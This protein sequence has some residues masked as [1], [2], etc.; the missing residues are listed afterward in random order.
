MGRGGENTNVAGR[1][2]CGGHGGAK[3]RRWKVIKRPW[4]PFCSSSLWGNLEK[5]G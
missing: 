1:G 5:Y 3:G 2:G 4:S